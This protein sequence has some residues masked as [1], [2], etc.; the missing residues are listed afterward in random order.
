MAT[1]QFLATRYI[2]E[3]I[4]P[5]QIEARQERTITVIQLRGES[6]GGDELLLRRAL[7]SRI[8]EGESKLILDV[9]DLGQI[10]ASSVATLREM[11]KLAEEAGGDVRLAGAGI[12]L[13]TQLALSGAEGEFAKFDDVSA[14]VTSFDGVDSR[15][16]KHFDILEFVKEQASED[17]AGRDPK[18][19]E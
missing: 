6:L 17:A 2:G 8:Q 19:S 1:K 3:T 18:P 7:E 5:L 13:L 9:S 15:G 16:V 14:A 12:A 4:M 11:H 10:D